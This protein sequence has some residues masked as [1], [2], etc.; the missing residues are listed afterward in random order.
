M[1]IATKQAAALL[2]LWTPPTAFLP[3]APSQPLPPFSRPS[4]SPLGIFPPLSSATASIN[5]S[6]LLSVQLFDLL[7]GGKS[8]LK[9]CIADFYTFPDCFQ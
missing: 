5:H 2:P 9:W 8:G 3:A 7:M 1:I 6:H 4:S